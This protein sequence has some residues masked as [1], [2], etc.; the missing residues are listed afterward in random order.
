MVEVLEA[1]PSAHGATG[2]E[3]RGEHR[4]G[5]L[6]L[7]DRHLMSLL[8][9]PGRDVVDEHRLARRDL[10][11][12]HLGDRHWFVRVADPALDRVRE[13]DDAGVEIVDPDVDDLRVEDLLDLVAHEL[14]HR[15]EIELGRESLLD[16]V[17]DR[18]LGG[19]LVRL[20][21]QSLRLAEQA[22]VVERDA[23]AR[24]EGREQ[25]LVRLAE[26]NRHA[27]PPARRRR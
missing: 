24:R 3:W 25:P 1:D 15:L 11:A 4:Q 7:D 12:D 18:Q 21:E 27:R 9:L 5:R 14:V 6:T 2:G 8:E 17:D 19:A 26:G 20:G 13:V 22:G 23:H 10:G 16:A